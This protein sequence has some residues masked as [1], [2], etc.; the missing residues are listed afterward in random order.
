MC[1][2]AF[3]CWVLKGIWL[4][5]QMEDGANT[6]ILGSPQRNLRSHNDTLQSTKIKVCS[7]HE[8]TDFF[9]YIAT[10]FSARGQT[11]RISVPNLPRQRIW[12]GFLVLVIQF[13]T[14]GFISSPY[15]DNFFFFLALGI[16]QSWLGVV[17]FT[18]FI[19]ADVLRHSPTSEAPVQEL[20]GI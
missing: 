20:R 9:F 2:H 18:D 19:S 10:G 6:S 13:V 16:H 12:L 4:H 17:E 15:R 8:D 3:N 7:L 11:S 14:T 5:T 1:G